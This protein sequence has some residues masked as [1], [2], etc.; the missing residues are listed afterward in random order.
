V[1]KQFTLGKQERLKSRKQ[2]DELFREG[3]R[4]TIP[5]F[6]IHYSFSQIKNTALQPGPLFGAAVSS[7]AFK[8]AVDRNRVKRLMREAYRLQKGALQEQLKTQDCRLHVFFIYTGK[9][10]PGYTE[11]YEATG[12]V[13]DKLYKLVPAIP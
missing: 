4:F 13:L 12:K 5:P 1:A 10:L 6:R 3:K 11:V 2:T 9:Q 7:R 8:K